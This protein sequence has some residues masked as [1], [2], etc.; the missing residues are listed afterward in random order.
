M[1]LVIVGSL[2][3][4]LV[5]GVVVFAIHDDRAEQANKPKSDDK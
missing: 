3:L 1:I 4:V 2:F 5:V